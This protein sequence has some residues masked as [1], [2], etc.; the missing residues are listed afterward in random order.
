MLFIDAEHAFVI[1]AHE[2][3][4]LSSEQI[5][6]ARLPR[7]VKLV[8]SEDA[9]VTCTLTGHINR[10]W[11]KTLAKLNVPR[12]TE[13]ERHFVKCFAPTHQGAVVGYHALI[14]QDHQLN[15]RSFEQVHGQQLRDI[16]FISHEG[17]VHFAATTFSPNSDKTSCFVREDSVKALRD[18]QTPN[19][20]W[21][22]ASWGE[23]H[24]MVNLR[25]MLKDGVRVY[26]F[27]D[28]EEGTLCQVSANDK[29]AKVIKKGI[30]GV[31]NNV[32]GATTDRQLLCTIVTD[33]KII[34]M[35]KNEQVAGDLS[36]PQHAELMRL[37]RDSKWVTGI[38]G[39][40]NV[41]YVSS[42]TNPLSS[43]ITS[44]LKRIEA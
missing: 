44:Q 29:Q 9:G 32:T 34:N 17:K 1:P 23:G 35:T 31:L 43:L 27:L 33:D 14:T 28:C 39:R 41:A 36:Q 5:R 18:N 16:D 42:L 12:D 10:S 21:S 40:S 37:V 24:Q 2:L 4:Y 8:V 38:V 7:L 25:G 20:D 30:K 26:S 19:T 22:L 3:S 15:V 6:A 11:I 13:T